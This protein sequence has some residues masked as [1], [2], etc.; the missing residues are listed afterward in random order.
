MNQ[1]LTQYFHP[2]VLPGTENCRFVRDPPGTPPVLTPHR[3][4]QR[5]KASRY[6]S[7]ENNARAS[8]EYT[9]SLGGN[10]RTRTS[11]L[12]DLTS[13][14]ST[15]S[16]GN[17][18]VRSPARSGR[19]AEQPSDTT[20]WYPLN[21]QITSMSTALRLTVELLLHRLVDREFLW[22]AEESRPAADRKALQN[23]GDG[24]R[25]RFRRPHG[26]RTERT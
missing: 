20:P 14:A 9:I 15:S 17:T 12:R 8:T 11:R 19:P 5:P 26:L 2:E 18:S 4:G 6:G 10:S 25:D 13:T 23:H 22:S 3:L 21:R 7:P 24:L 1:Q 16:G